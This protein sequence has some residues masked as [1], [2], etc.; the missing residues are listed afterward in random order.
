MMFKRPYREV[1]KSFSKAWTWRPLALP[2]QL[3]RVYGPNRQSK[4][5]IAMIADWHK[6]ESSAWCSPGKLQRLVSWTVTA[7]QCRVPKR[8]L[9]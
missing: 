4:H 1:V 5:R 6:R 9:S 8:L 2:A 7:A 3:P